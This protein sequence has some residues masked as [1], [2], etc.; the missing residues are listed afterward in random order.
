MIIVPLAAVDD[1]RP[2]RFGW[3]MYSA[4]VDLPRI[5]VQ[6]ASGVREERHIGHIASGFRPEVDYFTPI[7]RHL[8]IREQGAVTVTMTRI[9]PAR[10]VVIQC[11]TS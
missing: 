11:A 6:L 10:E 5:E 7:A 1:Q 9:H 4:A 3:Q 8:C 2:A